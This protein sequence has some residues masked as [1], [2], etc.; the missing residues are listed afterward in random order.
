ML[1]GRPNTDSQKGNEIAFQRKK[2]VHVSETYVKSAM[3]ERDLH[4]GD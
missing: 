2:S 4:E 1:N 3:A